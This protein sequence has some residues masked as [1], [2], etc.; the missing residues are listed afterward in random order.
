MNKPCTPRGVRTVGSK[1]TDATPALSPRSVGVFRPDR[2][3]GRSPLYRAIL[4]MTVERGFRGQAQAHGWQTP[5]F[6]EIGCL[7]PWVVLQCSGIIRQD[8]VAGLHHV[9]A[10]GNLEPSPR[11]L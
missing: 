8:D 5:T 9:G 1:D 2:G 6:A 3:G 11:G 7:D 10:L 4:F